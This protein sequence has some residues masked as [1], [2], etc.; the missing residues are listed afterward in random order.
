VSDP[1]EECPDPKEKSGIQAWL[2]LGKELISGSEN[3]NCKRIFRFAKKDCWIRKVG[4][5]AN[6]VGTA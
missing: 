5:A 4:S 1:Q 2:S 3:L 6:G